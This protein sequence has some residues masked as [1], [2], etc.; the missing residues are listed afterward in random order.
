MPGGF[1]ASARHAT[2]T[3]EPPTQMVPFDT[4]RL[5][6]ARSAGKLARVAE[7]KRE[8]HRLPFPLLTHQRQA[9]GLWR[10]EPRLRARK[11]GRHLSTTARVIPQANGPNSPAQGLS[12]ASPLGFVGHYGDRHPLNVGVSLSRHRKTPDR[13]SEWSGVPHFTACH[14]WRAQ[15]GCNSRA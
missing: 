13:W 5:R 4:R 15:L 3:W 2:P 11:K 12:A 9:A 10:R 14:G 7:M 6:S 8:P 1:A